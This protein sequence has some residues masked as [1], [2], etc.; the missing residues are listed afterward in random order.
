LKAGTEL[1]LLAVLLPLLPLRDLLSLLGA[2]CFFC[3]EEFA[4]GPAALGPWYMVR[5]VIPPPLP[6]AFRQLPAAYQLPHTGWLC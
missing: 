3:A 5:A 4:A 6:A 1:P 2:L